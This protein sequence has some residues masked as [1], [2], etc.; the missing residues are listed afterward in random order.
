MV[1]CILIFGVISVLI[2]PF[3][4]L[5]LFTAKKT[6]LAWRPL[7]RTPLARTSL[8]HQDGQDLKLSGVQF[9][10]AARAKSFGYALSGLRHVVTREHNARIHLGVAILVL[11]TAGY[12]GVTRQELTSLILVIVAVCFAETMNTAFEHLCDV[13]SP[14]KNPSVKFAKDIAAGAVLICAFGAAA[15]GFNIFAPYMGEVLGAHHHH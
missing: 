11:M 8:S 13:V 5:G 9:S 1:C 14:E 3:R 7:V 2:L 15:V 6:P 12:L 10:W 4:W